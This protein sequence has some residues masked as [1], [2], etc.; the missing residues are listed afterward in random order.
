VPPQ[1]HPSSLGFPTHPTPLV[2]LSNVLVG[3]KGSVSMTSLMAVNERAVYNVDVEDIIPVLNVSRPA[4]C[5][6]E[7]IESEYK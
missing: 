4:G 5:G 2:N 1:Q 6:R 3:L 7:V